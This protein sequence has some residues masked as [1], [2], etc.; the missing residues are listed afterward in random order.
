MT[1]EELT[2]TIDRAYTAFVDAVEA[3]GKNDQTAIS[4]LCVVR[5]DRSDR[6]GRD[7]VRCTVDSRVSDPK[8]AINHMLDATASV[9]KHIPCHGEVSVPEGGLN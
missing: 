1:N 7:A 9:L 3:A 5:I 4:V 8:A 2:E 6:K